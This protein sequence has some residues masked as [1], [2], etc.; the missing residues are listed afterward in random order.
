MWLI[1]SHIYLSSHFSPNSVMQI[2]AFGQCLRFRFCSSSFGWFMK[3]VHT[4]ISLDRNPLDPFLHRVIHGVFQRVGTASLRRNRHIFLFKIKQ[5]VF[6]KTNRLLQL[7]LLI[8]F[9]G[10]RCQKEEYRFR[11]RLLCWIGLRARR[12]PVTSHIMIG[13]TFYSGCIC[14]WRRKTFTRLK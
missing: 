9:G 3:Y 13:L 12:F 10:K 4:N 5:F 14:D 7:L 8:N 1:C 6:T 2:I 11:C